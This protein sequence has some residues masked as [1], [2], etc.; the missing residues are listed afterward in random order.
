MFF[1]DGKE[2]EE[3]Q[4][5]ESPQIAGLGGLQNAVDPQQVTNPFCNPMYQEPA[6]QPRR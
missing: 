1:Q 5:L 4:H 2:E 3:P 6:G